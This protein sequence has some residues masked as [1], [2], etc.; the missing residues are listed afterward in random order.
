MGAS[1]QAHLDFARASGRVIF[2]H[3]TDFLSL[4]ASGQLHAGI[5]YTHQR[6]PV[7]RIITGLVLIYRLLEAEE[8]ENRIEFI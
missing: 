5:V 1:D 7:G 2:T 6:T 8:M 3:D 4:A